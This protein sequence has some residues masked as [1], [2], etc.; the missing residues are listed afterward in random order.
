MTQTQ[1][2]MA[3]NSAARTKRRR[4]FL[5]LKLLLPMV[6]VAAAYA[7]FLALANSKPE[8]KP[9][10]T[11]E[12]AWTVQTIAV[13]I[14]DHRPELKLYGETVAG[15]KVDLRALVAGEIIQTVKTF[16][17]G[18]I[19][20]KGETLLTIDPFEFK[21]SL[22]EAKANLSEAKA[23]LEEINARVELETDQINASK[24]ELALAVRDVDRA[25][26]LLKQKL[27]SQKAVDDR[28]YT[29]SQRTQALS[30]RLSNLTI[31]QAKAAQQEAAILRLQSMVSRAERNLNNTKL[32]AP[33]NA[34]ISGINA[35]T[36][37]M[38]GT[39]DTI[40]TLIDMDRIDIRFNF[41]DAQFG[42]IIAGDK[43]VVGRPVKV[44]WRIGTTAITY[45]AVIERV[46][47]QITASSGGVEIYARLQD[48]KA[49]MSLRPGAFVEIFIHDRTF[50]QVA[51][52]PETSLYEG[53]KVFVINDKRRLEARRVELM[54]YA[55][56]DILV[57]G[58]LKPGDRVVT[59]R[60]SQARDGLLVEEK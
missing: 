17:E 52:L 35:E 16:R 7:S 33:F 18:G 58:A 59:T 43:T 56:N 4:G 23:K 42:R 31:E 20:A 49:G 50:E 57:R 37:R 48:P 41:S 22:V 45:K 39:N 10:Q 60:I 13:Q 34:Y 19:V 28:E 32:V 3:K 40:A 21:A 55:Q 26:E 6:I 1:T 44:V 12:K 29:M 30:Q 24:N 54:G 14:A 38:V 9:R 47:A 11:R 46:A 15:R 2:R 27:V 5:V 53:D 8:T 25:R 51:R 36:G